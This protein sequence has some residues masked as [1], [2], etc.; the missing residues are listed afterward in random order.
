MGKRT[1]ALLFIIV[2]IIVSAGATLTVLWLWE[3]AH[4]RPEIIVSISPEMTTNDPKDQIDEVKQSSE[5][6]TTIP[7]INED[8]TIRIRSIVG[9]GD[10]EIEYVEIVNQGQNPADLTGWQLVDESGHAF[11]FPALIL[12]SNGAIKVL[13]RPGTN[14]VIEL[15]WQSDSPIWQPGETARLMNTDGELV[16][17]YTIP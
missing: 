3:Q 2:N 12:N 1:R 9:A 17:S 16:T 10:L 14:T 15:Y 7:F 4:P 11:T 5:I 6:K 8:L 13:S